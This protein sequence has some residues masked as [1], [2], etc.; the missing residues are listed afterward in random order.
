L[1]AYLKEFDEEFDVRKKIV[2]DFHQWS[3]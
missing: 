1:A 2:R 3:N